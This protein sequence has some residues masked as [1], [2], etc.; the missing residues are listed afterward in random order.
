MS[1]IRP[2]RLEKKEIN[3][4][5]VH[6]IKKNENIHKKPEKYLSS[7]RRPYLDSIN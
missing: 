7:K 1:G 6:E 3:I 5:K 4:P 2:I